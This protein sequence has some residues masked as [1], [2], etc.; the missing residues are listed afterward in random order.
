MFAEARRLG[1][2]QLALTGGEPRCDLVELCAAPA[3]AGLYTTLITAGTPF[4]R[5][6]AEALEARARHRAGVDPEPGPEVND[7]IAGNG[8]SRRRSRPRASRGSSTSR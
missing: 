6:R 4:T 3:T 7:R 1:V 5:D 8:R 2:L